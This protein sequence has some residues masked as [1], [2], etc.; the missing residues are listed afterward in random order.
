MNSNLKKGISSILIFLLLP[1]PS[2]GWGIKFRGWL[3]SKLIKQCGK[4]LSLSS[5]VNIYNPSTLIC[6]DN[7]YLGYCSYI[8]DGDIRLGDEVVIG[9]YVSITAGNH[10][11]KDGSVRFGGYAYKPISIGRGTWIG[12]HASILSGVTIGKGCIVAAGSVVVNDVEDGKIVGGAPARILKDNDLES[13]RQA[14]VQ[15]GLKK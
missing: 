2:F 15:R 11:F 4:N 5:L 10:L 12:A 3:Y 7:V 8:G 1:L 6:G 9:P 14:G 13:G